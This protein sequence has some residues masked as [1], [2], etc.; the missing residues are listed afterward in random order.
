MKELENCYYCNSVNVYE[1]EDR[2]I[3]FQKSTTSIYLECVDCGDMCE[4]VYKELEL[5]AVY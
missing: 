2:V 3:D 5:I 1:F 4:L